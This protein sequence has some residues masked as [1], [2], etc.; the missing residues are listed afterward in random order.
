MLFAIRYK[1]VE[2]VGFYIL[3]PLFH[4]ALGN[5]VGKDFPLSFEHGQA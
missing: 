1:L 5:L 3:A 2:K 4:M